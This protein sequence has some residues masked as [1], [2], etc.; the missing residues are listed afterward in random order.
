M[1]RF[2]QVGFGLFQFRFGCVHLRFGLCRFGIG[3]GF[4]RIFGRFGG[5]GRVQISL[6]FGD[7]RIMVIELTRRGRIGRGFGRI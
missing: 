4:G 6:R 2:L 7:G 1:F 3:R 5:I